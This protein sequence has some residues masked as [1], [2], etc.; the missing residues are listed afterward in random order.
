MTNF[1]VEHRLNGHYIMETIRG[2]E[3]VDVS[4][5]KELLGIWVCN[6]SEETNVMENKLKE[7]RHARSGQPS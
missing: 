6:S 4:R 1:I 2:V 3:D 5:F 7:M